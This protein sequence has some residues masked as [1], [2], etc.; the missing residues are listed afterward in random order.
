MKYTPTKYDDLGLYGKIKNKIYIQHIKD[1]RKERKE[2]RKE[3]I[4]VLKDK[5]TLPEDIIKH[6][7]SFIPIAAKKPLTNGE[8]CDHIL[9][10][11]II[12]YRIKHVS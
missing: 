3:Y 6:V 9:R 1:F 7:V 4:E 8:L 10:E 12:E 5:F 11:Y 2:T